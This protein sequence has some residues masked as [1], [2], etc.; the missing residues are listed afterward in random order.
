[1]A[2]QKL[3]AEAEIK[4]AILSGWKTQRRDE[5]A[6]RSQK[7]IDDDI[8]SWDKQIAALDKAIADEKAKP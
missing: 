1:M 2:D 5:A 6:R 3:I 7:S 4:K 8:A